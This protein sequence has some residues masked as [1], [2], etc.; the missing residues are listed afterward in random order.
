MLAI[1][2]YNTLLSSWLLFFPV[3]KSPEGEAQTKSALANRENNDAMDIDEIN[4]EHELKSD[5]KLLDSDIQKPTSS[6]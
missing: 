6:S 1:G 2:S 5:D 3:D 4:D